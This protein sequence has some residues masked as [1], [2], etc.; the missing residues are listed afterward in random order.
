M[1]HYIVEKLTDKTIFMHRFQILRSFAYWSPPIFGQVKKFYYKKDLG[2]WITFTVLYFIQAKMS[3][4]KKYGFNNES[5]VENFY[6]KNVMVI[7]VAIFLRL[8]LTYDVAIKSTV[9]FYS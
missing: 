4:N 2:I 6:L 3:N 5:K 7:L 1:A 9:K 8:T